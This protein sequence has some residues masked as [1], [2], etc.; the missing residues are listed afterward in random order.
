MLV[1]TAALA[2]C[3][4]RPSEVGDA[5]HIVVVKSVRLPD[6]DWLPWYTRFAEHAWVDLEHDGQWYRIEWN[7]HQDEIGIDRISEERARMDERWERA[8]AVHGVVTGD[9]ARTLAKRVLACAKSFPAAADYRAWPGPNSNTFVDWLARET[10][11]PLHLPPNAVGKD[12][13]GWLRIGPSSSGSGVEL[14]TALAGVQVGLRE[15]IE[16]HVI[17][18]TLGVGLW[19]PQLKLPFLPAIPGGWIAPGKDD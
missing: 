18:L 2:A 15:G 19:P 6:R 4:V 17:G 12:Y 8:I 11:L 13:T 1:L 3:A 5:T 7:Q 10:G 9:F 16:L 14:E